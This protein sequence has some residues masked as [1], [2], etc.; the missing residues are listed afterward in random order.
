MASPTP[1][2]TLLRASKSSSPL[3]STPAVP[4]YLFIRQTRTRTRTRPFTTTTPK[5]SQ[6]R[7][8]TSIRRPDELDTLLFLSAKNNKPLITLFITRFDNT[9]VAPSELLQSLIVD[10]QVG[11]AEGGLDFAEVELDA[12]T[13]GDLEQR[14]SISSIPT[15]QAFSRQE[16]QVETRVTDLKNLRDKEFLRAW[17]RVEARRGG[18]GGAG[19]TGKDVLN[20]VLRAVGFS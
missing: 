10:E 16:P 5:P 20:K 8:H 3:L 4:K 2:T 7:M 17:L 1:L 18:A 15:L 13:I 9:N 12:A 11:Q 14:Y 19:G 6:N